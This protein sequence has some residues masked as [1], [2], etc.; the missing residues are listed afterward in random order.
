MDIYYT[1]TCVVRA[2]ARVC[3]YGRTMGRYRTSTCYHVQGDA[4]R[5]PL[6][7]R[8]NEWGGK[9]KTKRNREKKK[10]NPTHV[11]GTSVSSSVRVARAST[12][13]WRLVGFSRRGPS[14]VIDSL[15]VPGERAAGSV[16]V[17]GCLR[18]IV[19]DDPWKTRLRCAR[20][21]RV[22]ESPGSRIFR[23]NG[24]RWEAVESSTVETRRQSGNDCG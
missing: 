22:V 7:K 8:R 10:K 6:S 9:K 5:T 20:A 13:T 14:S 17:G 21:R 11:G 4:R 12:T 18:N 3:T 2:R 15:T 1:Y 23:Q 19:F 24:F 16:L